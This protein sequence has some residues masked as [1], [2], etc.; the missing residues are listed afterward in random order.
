MDNL[1]ANTDNSTKKCRALSLMGGGVKGNYET[2]VLQSLYD[3]LPEGEVAWDVT[4]GVS[5]G[6]INAASLGIYAKGDEKAAIEKMHTYWK[7]LD[8]ST[9]FVQWPKWS[10]LAGFWKNSFF[11]NT[12]SH[13]SVNQRL[14]NPFKR[15]VAF[16]SVNINDGKVYQFDE[17]LSPKL[18]GEAVVASASIPVAF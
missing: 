13:T 18:Q 6:A 17:K 1:A 10:I 2:G 8:T 9:I 5:I 16:Q 15:R 14:V 12:P 3:H 7:I 4:T 11:D